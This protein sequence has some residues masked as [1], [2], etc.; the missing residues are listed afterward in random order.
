MKI[1]SWGQMETAF[2]SPTGLVSVKIENV[3]YVGTFF[4]SV[5]SQSILDS[6]GIHLDTGGPHLYKDNKIKFLLH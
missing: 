3:A 2:E 1:E 4:T 5:I 6:K